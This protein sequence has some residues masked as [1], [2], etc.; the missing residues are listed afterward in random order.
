MPEKWDQTKPDDDAAVFRHE[1]IQRAAKIAQAFKDLNNEDLKN[2]VEIASMDKD[3][4][5]ILRQMVADRKNMTW[6]GK[7]S[8]SLFSKLLAVAVGVATVGGFI[9]LIKQGHQ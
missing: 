6:L 2:L 7:L 8:W 9:L 1:D 4:L 3:D 5:K